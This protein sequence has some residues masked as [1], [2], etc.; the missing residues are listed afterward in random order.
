ME[1]S[2]LFSWMRA[3]ELLLP[4]LAHCGKPPESP[5]PGRS[6]QSPP[7]PEPR[8]IFVPQAGP[9]TRKVLWG[10]LPAVTA[11]RGPASTVRAVWGPRTVTCFPPGL[12]LS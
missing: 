11:A 8:L 7:Q 2:F 3:R 6:L 4:A 10:K 12:V 5:V 9:C 1:L